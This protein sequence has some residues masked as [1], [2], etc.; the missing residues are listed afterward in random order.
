LSVFWSPFAG[1][2][3][4]RWI[5]A[6]GDLVMVLIIATE[7][8]P[9]AA[10][11]RLFSRLG[12]ILMPASVLLIHYSDLGHGWDPD[13]N[14]MN[15]GVTNNKNTLGLI[16]FIILLGA[17]WRFRQVLREKRRPNYKRELVG[18]GTLLVFGLATLVMAHSA[19]SIACFALGTTL[20]LITGLKSIRRRPRRVHT[21]VTATLLCVGLVML[22]G[23]EGAVV[24]ALGRQTN[25]TGRSDIWKAVI[26]A[27]PNWL[28]GAGF[29]SFWIGP[30]V[31]EVYRSLPKFNQ[32]NEAHNGY[33]EVYL[34]LGVIGLFLIVWILI[35]GYRHAV[36]TFRRNPE[37]G[38]LMLAYVA[39][40]VIYSVTEAGFRMLS[41][42]W[43]FLLLALETG[44]GT[45]AG[46]IGNNTQQLQRKHIR[47]PALGGPPMHSV[48]ACK[49]QE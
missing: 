48:N 6:S 32:V 24:H 21:V 1:V 47:R 5:K 45:A 23:G 20:M 33:I 4:K 42:I 18:Q 7:P 31:K 17:V 40:S 41:P 36:S 35:S 38:G 46:L 26:P 25:F 11:R 30:T 34:N 14:L 8:D 37:L 12:F 49:V 16:T 43:I 39:S 10:L 15:T 29:E 27:C 19:T 28:I 3:L 22:L 9:M 2:A 13:G 44:I